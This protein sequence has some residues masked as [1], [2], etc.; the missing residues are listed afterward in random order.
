MQILIPVL[1]AIAVGVLIR[2]ISKNNAKEFI[3]NLA[4]EHITVRLPKAYLWIGCA[5][6]CFFCG[7]SLLAW[8]TSN[9]STGAWVYVGF[10]LFILLG[11]L[12][13]HATVTIRVELFRSQDFFIIRTVFLRT[14][15]V[16]FA[17]CTSY[18]LGSNDLILYTTKKKYH[19]DIQS[20]NFEYLISELAK[21]KVK[22]VCANRK[23]KR[24]NR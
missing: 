20:T 19:I 8:Y 14:H 17:D 1:A 21:H 12:L 16:Y 23:L 18:S 22:L 9:E 15:K 10:G 11:L 13:I 2:V 4:S 3:K 6:T 24:S 7:C 5:G